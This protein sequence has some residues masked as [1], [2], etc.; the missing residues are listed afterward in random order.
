MKAALV[1]RGGPKVPDLAKL[2]RYGATRLYWE[3]ADN[4]V[5]ASL[6]DAV[7]AKGFEVGVMRD[8][9]WD[10][11]N[12]IQLAETLNADVIR[13][14]S[15]AKQCA[16]MADI[17]LHSPGYVLSF[18]TEWRKLRPTRPLAWTLEPYQAGW[19]SRDLVDKINADPNLIV[20]PQLYFGDMTPQVESLVAMDVQSA[21]VSRDRVRC[22]YGLKNAVKAWD[23]CL[24]DLIN[25]PEMA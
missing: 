14:G 5:D 21:G 6:L 25:L 7:R 16:V 15:N 4:Q 1:L 9:S 2:T 10:G 3:A 17:E 20:L 12:P 23:G 11:A 19:F 8:P 24:Y 18:I 13:L 22:F